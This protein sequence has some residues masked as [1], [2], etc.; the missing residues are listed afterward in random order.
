MVLTKMAEPIYVK[1]ARKGVAK[2][3]EVMLTDE[4]LDELAI[5][6]RKMQDM[7]FSQ[8]VLNYLE[9]QKRKQQEPVCI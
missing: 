6:Y 5:K 4:L 1:F 3:N 2:M 7:T 9:E 8:F